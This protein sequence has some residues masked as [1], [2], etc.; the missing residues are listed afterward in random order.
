MIKHCGLEK[1]GVELNLAWPFN[2]MNCENVVRKTKYK[3]GLT[4][5]VIRI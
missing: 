3:Q 1:V 2:K 4:G 5:M